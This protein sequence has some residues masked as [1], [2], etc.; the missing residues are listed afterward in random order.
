MKKVIIKG[1]EIMLYESIDEM[2]IANFQKYN[3]CLLIDS[4]IGSNIDDIDNHIVKIA[5]Y[6]KSNKESAIKELKNMRQNL[7]M[8]SSGISPKYLAFAAL[9]HSI[10]GK[11]LT[12]LSDTNLSSILE[13]F[14]EVKHSWLV[15]LLAKIKKKIN[16]ELELYFPDEFIN[17]KE[18]E[19]Y[20]RLKQR[21]LLVLEG[22]KDSKDNSSE[23]DKIDDYL[24]G[25]H[26][27]LSFDGDTSAEIKYD[28]QYET[29]CILIAQKT[30]LNAK[31]MTVLQFYS[32]L[33]SMKRQA[34]AEKK[35]TN[36]HKK[37]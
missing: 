18:K 3:K 36:R 16:T 29:M 26:K 21:T 4:G 8:I 25:L 1:K 9:I 12:D 17:P 30:N 32:A 7:I 10:D 5:R 14:K 28:K 15:D 24:F 6:I 20:D 2:P 11:A 37:R 23:I 13:S 22:I 19:T 33:D 31:A 35:I 27:P 34:E